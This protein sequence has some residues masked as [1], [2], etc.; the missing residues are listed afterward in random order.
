MTLTNHREFW[1]SCPAG[2]N[3]LRE[4]CSCPAHFLLAE[5]S[6]YF[7]NLILVF[8]LVGFLTFSLATRLSCGRVP[9]L[10]P[11]NFACCTQTQS[12]ET[13]PLSCTSESDWQ[14]HVSNCLARKDVRWL[15]KLAG[16]GITD[17]CTGK[18]RRD[19]DVWKVMITYTTQQGT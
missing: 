11:D 8:C 7:I 14:I 15:D 3:F 18:D 2:K 12:G 10:L 5:T 13:C 1:Y 16:F 6:S 19:W 9:R 17:R 4:Y